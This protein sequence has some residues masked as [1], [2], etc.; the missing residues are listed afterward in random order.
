[1]LCGA[2]GVKLCGNWQGWGWLGVPGPDRC[3]R[4]VCVQTC[5]GVAWCGLVDCEVLKSLVGMSILSQ[6]SLFCVD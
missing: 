2:S 1:M 4:C 3:M 6:S 5:V